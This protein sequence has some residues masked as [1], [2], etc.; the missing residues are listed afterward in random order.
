M[1]GGVRVFVFVWSMLLLALPAGSTAAIAPDPSFDG[2]GRQQVFPSGLAG[3]EQIF[4]RD[5]VSDVTVDHE[6]RIVIVGSAEGKLG[7]DHS[8]ALVARFTPDGALDKSFS[9]DGIIHFEW[10]PE[11]SDATAVAI[12]HQDRIVVGG[13]SAN[14]P[15]LLSVSA[16]AR[17]L[18][19]GA[20]DPT[21]G[22]DGLT[23][24]NL[25]GDV[26]GVAVDAQDRVLLAT[27]TRSDEHFSIIRLTEDGAVDESFGGD[28]LVLTD[29]PGTEFPSSTAI[30]VDASGRPVVAGEVQFSTGSALAIARYTE[31]GS[32]DPSFDGD[33]RTLLDFGALTWEE[34]HEVLLDGSGRVVVVGKAGSGVALLGR[35]LPDGEPDPSFGSA[36]RVITGRPA[37]RLHANSAAIDSAGRIVVAGTIEGEQW[38]YTSEDAFL[39]RYG[40]N[41]E[42]EE[43]IAPDGFVRED[44][45]AANVTNASV[46]IDQQGR[47][48][49]AGSL[50]TESFGQ[51]LGFIGLARFTVDYPLPL[52]PAQQQS[53]PTPPRCHGEEATIAG[54]E[55]RDVLRGTKRKDVMVG[56]GGN[57]LLLGFGGDDLICAG[58]GDDTIK[59]GAGNDVLAGEAGEDR[60][61]G[62]DG[63]DRLIAGGGVD[64]SDCGRD[65]DIALVDRLDQVKHCERVTRRGSPRH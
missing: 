26:R 47:Y 30:A 53:A 37:S 46:A 2:D 48:L 43:N 11:H 8:E 44:F 15:S 9:G 61:F 38:P 54:T 23:T 51:E 55:A 42:L 17:F 4:S 40:A 21:F 25:G 58:S 49:L 59:A 34:A 6:G 31:S 28:G 50:F 16:I 19:N 64:R 27:R 36:G 18:P 14:Y 57:D 63:G 22:E 32:L 13:G 7:V 52:P 24:T 39:L 3:Y 60:L 35:L 20:P 56:L 45:L 10:E 41:G 65:R 12:D 62:G 29:F 1:K 33:G 5:T